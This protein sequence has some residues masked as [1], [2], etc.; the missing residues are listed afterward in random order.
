[1][2]HARRYGA[3]RARIITSFAAMWIIPQSF[4]SSV[5]AVAPRPFG[6]FSGVIGSPKVP[7]LPLA[8][9]RGEVFLRR[10]NDEPLFRSSSVRKNFEP[11]LPRPLLM[12]SGRYAW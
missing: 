6:L 9:R 5:A 2:R 1:L 11:H 8:R 4:R 12:S 7:L 10:A 3:R